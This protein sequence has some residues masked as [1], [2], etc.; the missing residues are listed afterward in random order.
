MNLF[1]KATNR[2]L[3]LLI[4]LGISAT[5]CSSSEPSVKSTITQEEIPA[6]S[7][8][9]QNQKKQ[10]QPSQNQ[11]PRGNRADQG[12]ATTIGGGSS[13]SSGQSQMGPSPVATTVPPQIA[14]STLPRFESFTCT[15]T[16]NDTT[17]QPTPTTR[18]IRIDVEVNQTSLS[19]VATAVTTSGIIKRLLIPINKLGKGYTQVVVPDSAISYVSIFASPD[20]FPE[21]TMCS[22]Q[23]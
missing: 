10:A 19:S 5:G 21:S 23:G 2:T 14:P 9:T 17:Q 4:L 3:L 6:T 16:V 15:V 1:H 13:L 20:F 7:L 12:T 22:N 18:A 11:K 8:V